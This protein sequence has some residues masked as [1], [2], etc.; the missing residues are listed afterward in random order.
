MI[1]KIYKI[2]DFIC[3]YNLY[4]KKKLIIFFNGLAGVKEFYF[5]FKKYSKN[6]GFL[7][8]DF[9]GFGNSVYLK[10]PKNIISDHIK[11]LKKVIEIEK[12]LKF[13]LVVFSLS[14]SY[15]HFLEKDK[16]FMKRVN[17][18]FLIDPSIYK[19]D[20]NWSLN[21]FKMKK[22]NFK[23]YILIYKKNLDNLFSMSLVKPR[24]ISLITDQ[25]KKFDV[26]IL[27][28]L[29]K[30]SVKI[31]LKNKVSKLVNNKKYI[32]INPKNKPINKY[33]KKNLYKLFYI[34]NSKHYLFL[35]KPNETYKI[36]NKYA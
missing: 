16:N 25:L 34:K 3:H 5:N 22:K 27:Y 9:P 23:K 29:N 1:K 12:I 4:K 2:N 8:I 30:E 24:R 19:S 21:L 18:I 33:I 7:T 31:I 13:N 17:K 11:I 15:L 28:S 20:L 6:K 36:I 35:D 32:I 10:K 26:E 14:T